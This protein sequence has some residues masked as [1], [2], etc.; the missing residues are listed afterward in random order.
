MLINKINY[1]NKIEKSIQT[2]N[3]KLYEFLINNYDDLIKNDYRRGSSY[4]QIVVVKISASDCI[5]WD[6]LTEYIGFWQSS[7]F[8]WSEEYT[9]NENKFPFIRVNKKQKEVIEK[10]TYYEPVETN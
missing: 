8:I 9:D 5:K 7:K 10:V 4:Y 3:P 1:E 2:E 6:I